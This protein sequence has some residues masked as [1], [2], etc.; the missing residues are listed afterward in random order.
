MS[1]HSLCHCTIFA[2]KISEPVSELRKNGARAQDA[3]PQGRY[4]M[5][6]KILKHINMPSYD[7]VM[8][9]SPHHDPII[10]HVRVSA[11]TS[12][13]SL[14]SDLPPPEWESDDDPPEWESSSEEDHDREVSPCPV[15]ECGHAKPYLNGEYVVYELEYAVTCVGYIFDDCIIR[16]RIHSHNRVGE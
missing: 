3:S 15:R 8:L 6:I 4:Y 2:L 11:G 5:W 16:E 7:G 12:T 9:C 13:G 10:R 1:R 14:N